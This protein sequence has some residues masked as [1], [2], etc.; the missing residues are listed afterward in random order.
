MVVTFST[1]PAVLDTLNFVNA[2]IIVRN[3]SCLHLLPPVLPLWNS[4]M[5]K[6]L[7]T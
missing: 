7:Y 6:Y 3:L 4:I 2:T 5:V 1:S